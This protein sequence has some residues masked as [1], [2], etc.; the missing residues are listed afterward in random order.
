MITS[1]AVMHVATHAVW[2]AA[3]RELKKN[4]AYGV[5]HR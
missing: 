5:A 2:S 1:A 4:T 3:A